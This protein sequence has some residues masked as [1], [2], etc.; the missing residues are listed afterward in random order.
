MSINIQIGEHEK[1]PKGFY[2]DLGLDNNDECSVIVNDPHYLLGLELKVERIHVQEPAEWDE[3]MCYCCISNVSDK[4]K[5]YTHEYFFNMYV[6]RELNIYYIVND[7]NREIQCQYPIDETYS[8]DLDI[9]SE[10]LK[11]IF[12]NPPE[13]VDM[14]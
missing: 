6:N 8:E 2:F 11:L 5:I 13:Y 1:S 12:M 7:H 9:Y 3:Y 14:S 10:L 4:E